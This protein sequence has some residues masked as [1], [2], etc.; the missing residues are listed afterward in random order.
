MEDICG[1]VS[2]RS[3]LSV[4]FKDLG[5]DVLNLHTL[6][7]DTHFYMCRLWSQFTRKTYVLKS[8]VLLT[9]P[10]RLNVYFDFLHLEKLM[11]EVHS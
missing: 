7:G 8:D 4:S 11:F 6:H 5:L 1:A 3:A 10:S 2:S 9:D